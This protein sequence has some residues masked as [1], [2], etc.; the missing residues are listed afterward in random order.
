MSGV[1]RGSAV[2]ALL[3]AGAAACAGCTAGSAGPPP[4]VRS[5]EAITDRT[6]QWE[7]LVTP[8]ETVTVPAPGRYT[9]EL[10]PNGRVLINA[11]CNRGSGTFRAENGRLAFEPFTLTRVACA[12]GS[13]D[14]RYVEA[15]QRTA[16][17]FLEGGALHLEL[18]MDSG[19]LRFG[20]A[21]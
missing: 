21:R 14:A 19:T 10:A 12:P 2:A 18:P 8:V 17:F 7:A 11:D 6:W 16:S 5:L 3:A 1:L 4:R 13:L 9:L 20:P 15:L